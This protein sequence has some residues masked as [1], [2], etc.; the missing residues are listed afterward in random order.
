VPTFVDERDAGFIPR[1][2][3]VMICTGSQGE[4]RAALAR[5]AEDQHPHVVLERGDVAVFSSRVI[6]GNER[7]ILRMQNGLAR[8]GV[9][10]VTDHTHSDIH[11]SG[12]PARDELTR[13]YQWV[14]PQ[15]AIPVH[16]EM[17]H[18][19][20][21]AELAKTCQ[22]PHALVP[23]NGTLIRL[24]AEGAEIVDRVYAGR[25]A[26]IGDR[27][28]PVGGAVLKSRSR[29]MWNG[30]VI[31]TVV[32]DRKGRLA[33]TPKISAPGLLDPETDTELAAEIVAAIEEG[34]ERAGRDAGD[35]QVEQSVRRA[36]RNALRDRG[37][38][39][40]VIDIHLVRI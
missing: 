37:E 17:R 28:L 38:G 26:V 24:G 33:T 11:V 9:E 31:A 36:V 21:H 20:A 14:R 8:L 18:M 40:P 6:P 34:V 35:E 13:M 3:L 23:E 22:V 10:I 25:L 1:D 27:L 15:I 30:A 7:N 19:Q 39:R 4:S 16:G 32:L 5:I 29:L 2:K 12:H